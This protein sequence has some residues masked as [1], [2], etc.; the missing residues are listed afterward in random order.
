MGLFKNRKKKRKKRI[1][2]FFRNLP[3][4][5][6]VGLSIRAE[7]VALAK[8]MKRHDTFL[9]KPRTA[10]EIITHAYKVAEE[11]GIGISEKSSRWGKW[12]KL[13]TTYPIEI[14]VGS[15]FRNLTEAEQAIVLMHEL[16]HVRQWYEF[17][18]KKYAYSYVGDPRF[19]WA[20]EVECYGESLW[21]AVAMG[22]SK[23]FLDKYVH[24]RD[25]T[26]IESYLLLRPIKQ[27]HLRKH[28]DAI[29]EYVLKQAQNTVNR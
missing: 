20:M 5:R 7:D 9:D 14:R 12:S 26:L 11:L 6:N 16:R 25:D 15:N 17:G 22:G 27:T 23:S 10:K 18:I 4:L 3:V 2:K 24:N 21:T 1:K 19:G 29:M 8:S 28:T 13:S